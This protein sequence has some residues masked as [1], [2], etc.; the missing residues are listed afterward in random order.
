MSKPVVAIVGK[1]Q[2]RQTTLFNR[3]VGARK[4]YC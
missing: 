3:L 1:T 4:S 2:C